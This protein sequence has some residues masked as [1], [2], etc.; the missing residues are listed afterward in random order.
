MGPA[1]TPAASPA[2]PR[3]EL[4]RLDL[5]KR[6]I[7][8]TAHPDVSRAD[9]GAVLPFQDDALVLTHPESLEG[10][11]PVRLD[12]PELAAL[13]IGALACAALARRARR[14]RLLRQITTEEPDPE[15]SLSPPAI[16]AGILLARAAGLPALRAFEAANYGL[17]AA[18]ADRPPGTV[19]IRAVCVGA[20][21]VDFWL[22]DAGQPAPHGLTLSPDG[23]VWHAPHGTFSSVEAGSSAG[24]LGAGGSPSAPDRPAGGRGRSRDVAGPPRSGKLSPPPGRGRTRAV[25]GRPSGP[26]GLV[27]GRHGPGHRGSARR[28]RRGAVARRR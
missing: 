12:L 22:A 10:A 9:G 20:A 15:F 28:L 11:G 23:H 18:L 19:T 3:L 26:R 2:P 6:W 25:A 8:V 16:D 24:G 13:G 17:A 14:T 1:A 4:P 7:P 21:G 27:M 5:P